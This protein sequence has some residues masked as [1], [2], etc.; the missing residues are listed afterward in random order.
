MDALAGA[1][2]LGRAA[3]PR[4]GGGAHV[5][6]AQCV[7]NLTGDAAVVGAL[8]GGDGPLRGGQLHEDGGPHAGEA[9]RRVG[10]RGERVAEGHGGG[11]CAA[12]GGSVTLRARARVARN[13]SADSGRRRR[14]ER[15]PQPKILRGALFRPHA[16]GADRRRVGKRIRGDRGVA[17]G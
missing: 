13:R 11:R 14:A 7:L 5:D 10:A 2:A 4:M 16:A 8:A 6:G 1:S 9:V 12:P 3:R 17:A 15:R